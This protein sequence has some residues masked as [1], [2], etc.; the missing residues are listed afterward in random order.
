MARYL[1]KTWI[2]QW[3]SGLTKQNECESVDIEQTDT[4]WICLTRRQEAYKFPLS[5]ISPKIPLIFPYFVKS[6]GAVI[7]KLKSELLDDFGKCY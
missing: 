6:D 5:V 3:T 2:S 1:N 4:N 7:Y